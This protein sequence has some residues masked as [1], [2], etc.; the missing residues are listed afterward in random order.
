[1]LRRP[2]DGG[3]LGPV[4]SGSAMQ[5]GPVN[6]PPRSP[7]VPL[8]PNRRTPLPSDLLARSSPVTSS[9]SSS[10]YSGNR[11]NQSLVQPHQPSP[12]ANERPPTIV[13]SNGEA[14]TVEYVEELQAELEALRGLL[15]DATTA[16]NDIGEDYNTAGHI[17][18]MIYTGSALDGFEP[19]LSLEEPCEL[20]EVKV[21]ISSK[22]RHTPACHDGLGKCTRPPWRGV[23]T[24]SEIEWD[25]H[26]G[27]YSDLWHRARADVLKH[28]QSTMK[29]Y[30]RECKRPWRRFRTIPGGD[31][32]PLPIVGPLSHQHGPPR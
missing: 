19:E 8:I 20:E 26:L 22:C 12:L 31:L 4:E 14:V 1:M 6:E 27:Y 11:G 2:E 28:I 25:N 30:L 24:L 29:P 13:L 21:N 16:K 18:D 3:Y 17:L 15:R 9:P 7:N 5:H 10:A 23:L 32:G